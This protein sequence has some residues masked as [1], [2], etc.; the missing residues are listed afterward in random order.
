M[1]KYKII[2]I[3]IESS[4]SQYGS[5]KIFLPATWAWLLKVEAGNI[6]CRCAC[7]ESVAM[8]KAWVNNHR[9]YCFS[10]SSD[11]RSEV[12]KIENVEARYF[13]KIQ[14]LLAK[15]VLA[16][17]LSIL[18]LWLPVGYK[19]NTS[20]H[21]GGIDAEFNFRWR[22][23]VTKSLKV[24]RLPYAVGKQPSIPLINLGRNGR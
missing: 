5:D 3:I 22:G 10:S 16:I 8:I 9:G 14:N 12:A 21:Y 2:I 13:K 1:S 19:F 11:R 7:K 23:C 24:G 17:S 6:R 20:E 15:T 4:S 18:W